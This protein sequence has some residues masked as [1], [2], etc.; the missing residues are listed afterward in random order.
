VF[1]VNRVRNFTLDGFNVRNRPDPSKAA[2]AHRGISLSNSTGITIQNCY[3]DRAV[4]AMLFNIGDPDFS[5]EVTVIHNTAIGGQFADPSDPSIPNVYGQA[6]NMQYVAYYGPPEVC[7]TPDDTGCYVNEAPLP[8]G[9]HKLIVADN[10][11]RTNGSS[12][13]YVL[14]ENECPDMEIAI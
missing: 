1:G 3:F 14:F 12:V 5:S 11:F 9:N 7:E 2:N 10:A 6:V 13:R 8:T 4:Q